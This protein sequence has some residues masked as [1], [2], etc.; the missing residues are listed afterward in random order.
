MA[1]DLFPEVSM[2]FLTILSSLGLVPCNIS[3]DLWTRSPMSHGE[4][5]YLST[6]G[7]IVSMLVPV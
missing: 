4:Q 3:H 1:V 6:D 2:R 7:L 5:A